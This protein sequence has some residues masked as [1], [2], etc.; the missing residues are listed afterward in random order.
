MDA[1]PAID[2]RIAGERDTH[3]PWPVPYFSDRAAWEERAGHIRRHILTCLG[4]WPMPRKTPLRS[5]RGPVL[6]RRGYSVETVY[7]ESLPGF[8]VA[9]N[10]YMPAGDGP[11]S[12]ILTP[13]G[14]W[15]QGRLEDSELG[16]VPGRC[17]NLARQGHAVF[18]YDMVGYVDSLQVDHRDFGGRAGR[19]WGIGPMGLQ[20]WNSIRALDFIAGLDRVDPA[21]LGCTGASGGGTQTF[22]LAA[23]D[24]RLAAAATVNMVSAV[25]QGGCA[26]ENEGHLRLDLSNV[27]IA[28]LM[29]PRPLQL[30]G[31]SGDWTA[32]APE[33]EYPAIRRI[34]QLYGAE[35]K[36]HCTLVDAPHNYNRTSR[37]VV[38]GFFG[39]YFLG[40]TAKIAERPFRTEPDAALRVFGG[41]LP[42]AALDE[43]GV[44]D[45][46]RQR[47]QSRLPLQAP[48]SKKTLVAFGRRWRES[49][50]HALSVSN[51]NAEQIQVETGEWCRQ[52]QRVV[53]QLYL[54]RRSTGERVPVRFYRPQG[55]VESGRVFVLLDPQEVCT[56]KGDGLNLGVSKKT[57]R[58]LSALLDRGDTVLVP[59]LF[60]WGAAGPQSPGRL[61]GEKQDSPHFHTYN[62]ASAACRVQDVLTVAAYGRTWG[63]VKLIGLKGAAMEGLMAAAV[64][65]QGLALD[66]GGMAV[67]KD[68]YWNES[69]YVPAI[70]AVGDARSAL[71][72]AAT[73]PLLVGG[74]KRGF[75]RQ[76][77]TAVCQAGGG[78]DLVPALDAAA[79]L[80]WSERS[81]Q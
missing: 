67:D 7:F 43:A 11:V 16:S 63:E 78:L 37:E 52:G 23:V 79:V 8:Y 46:M 73:Q 22:M 69:F 13:H 9:G 70:R 17:I 18:S 53:Q 14:H 35:D 56:K 25:M 51:P 2:A 15:G 48:T 59:D 62:Q 42:A 49:L 54:G 31:A 28:A 61:Q 20:L 75:P 38:Y 74:D 81:P 72:L 40:R 27:E 66:W 30:V 3:T 34:Y 12:A 39:R 5:R 4:L 19:L 80:S 29:A 24:T 21:R 26:C 68:T 33:R 60:G 76:W 6:R 10:L 55:T 36:V 1:L 71:A 65:P 57:S 77:T 50:A 45:A 41:E 47:T 44:F 58:L 64:H 32:F